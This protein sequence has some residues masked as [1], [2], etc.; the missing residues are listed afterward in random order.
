MYKPREDS[1]LLE[2][3]LNLA[4][5]KVLE[6][7]TGSGFL[8]NSAAKNPDVSSVLAAD[9]DEE[10]IEYC[11]TYY[12]NRKLSFIVS[13]LFSNVDGKFDMSEINKISE[14]AQKHPVFDTIIFN[15]PYLPQDKGI[16]DK[17]LYGGKKGHEVLGKFF[18]QV[19]DYMNPACRILI[20]FS[21]LTDKK[22]VDE[23]IKEHGFSFKELERKHIFFEDLYV[24]LIE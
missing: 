15:P 12:Q 23:M 9:V 22:K 5:G 10:A 17:A 14:H 1:L 7:G 13:D 3:H 2:R 24:Y 20:V 11:E 6:I 16:E 18:A 19:R 4:K 21:S 8:A